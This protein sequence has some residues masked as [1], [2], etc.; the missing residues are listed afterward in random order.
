MAASKGNRIFVWIV[1]VLLAVG[2]VG[3]GSGG[4]TGSVRTIGTVG[5]KEITTQR[6]ANALNDQIRAFGAQIGMPLSFPQAEA[7]GLDQVVL[8][9]LIGT[10]ALDNEVARLGLSIGDDAISEQI[11]RAP[12]FQGLDGSFSRETYRIRLQQVGQTETEF[13]TALR[14]DLARNMLQQGV[15]GGLPGSETYAEAMV[16]HIGE[17]RSVTWARLSAGAAD[18]APP[19]PQEGDLQAFYEANPDAYTTPERRLISYAW[20]APSMIMDDLV[21]DEEAVRQLYEDRIFEFVQEERRLLE[22]L[23]FGTEEEAAAALARIEAGEVDFDDL[24]AER[25]L[26]LADIDLGDVAEGQLGESGAAVFAAASGEVLGPLPS[27]LGPALFRVN[28]ILAAQEVPFEEAEEMLRAEL[29]VQRAR[30]VIADQAEG[31][32]DLVAGGASIEDLVDRTAMEQGAIDWSLG[33]TDGIAAYEVFRAAAAE[34]QVGALPRLTELEDGGIVVLR[35]DEVIPPALLPFDEVADQ[36][37]ADWQVGALQRALRAEA[38]AIAADIGA[39]EAGPDIGFADPRLVV[40][41]EEGLLRRNFVPGTPPGFLAAVFEMEA[42]EV[43]VLDD[44]AD[45]ILLR[46]DAIAPVERDDPA[47]QAEAESI[48][49]RAGAGVAQ[50]LYEMFSR[51][52]IES[53]PLSLSDAAIQAVHANFR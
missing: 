44:G 5:D 1:I 32:T 27:T 14:E 46:L 33:Q 41:V 13:E 48:L 37:R 42:G 15:L 22:R 43:R 9:R 39:G 53:T 16:A 26:D 6:Y 47:M 36:V 40:T 7:M 23:V 11:L 10:R 30:R 31:I 17:R 49:E 3:F 45:A 20:L 51:Q 52:I 8:G 4:L 19:E 35:L 38:E 29:S 12:E 21:V 34:A 50:D 18:L 28:A 24:V 2:L 25:G